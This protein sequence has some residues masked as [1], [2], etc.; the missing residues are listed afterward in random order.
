ML[1]VMGRPRNEFWQKIYDLPRGE[2]LI[3]P[4]HS[5][6]SVMS[7]RSYVSSR[8]NL[9]G[10]RRVTIKYDY[11]SKTVTFTHKTTTASDV[12]ASKTRPIAARVAAGE[13]LT[14]AEA[15]LFKNELTRLNERVDK[16]VI[17]SIP[18]V[19][20]NADEGTLERAV[21]DIVNV[22]PIE[23]EHYPIGYD[24]RADIN[25]P[26]YDSR[27]DPNSDDYDYTLD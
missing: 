2:S 4:V 27:Y 20:W 3:V 16:L 5:P 8:I 10:E 26:E 24:P 23:S 25:R 12:F 1:L 15:D 6:E 7:W 19:P 17:A 21:A 18:Y 9:G 22:P 13:Q 11:E 14:R